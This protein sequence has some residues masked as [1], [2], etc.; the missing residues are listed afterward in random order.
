MN[1]S[2]LSEHFE[3]D[4]YPLTSIIHNNNSNVIAG[5][6][7][8]TKL[9]CNVNEFVNVYYKEQLILTCNSPLSFWK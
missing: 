1:E 6:E 5:N 3:D 8:N 9:L 7:V 2:N 4:A